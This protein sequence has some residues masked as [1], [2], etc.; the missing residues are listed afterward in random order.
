VS[1][2]VIR[3]KNGSGAAVNDGDQFFVIEHA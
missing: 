2:R 3:F 1:Q